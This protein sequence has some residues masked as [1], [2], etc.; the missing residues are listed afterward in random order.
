[1]KDALNL[2]LKKALEIKNLMKKSILNEYR[3]NN[4]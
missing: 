3:V 1:L 2:A 4:L